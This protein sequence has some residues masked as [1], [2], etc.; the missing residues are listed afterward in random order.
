MDRYVDPAARVHGAC[1]VVPYIRDITDET[2]Q[3]MQTQI[4]AHYEGS[5]TSPYWRQIS[6]RRNLL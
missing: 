1:A 5:L 6:K 2:I 4:S 3:K